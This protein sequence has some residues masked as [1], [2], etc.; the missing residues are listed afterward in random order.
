MAIREVDFR[1]RIARKIQHTFIRQVLWVL[2][3][4]G[5]DI[6]GFAI[7][8]WDTRGVTATTIECNSSPIGISMVPGF[9]K[10]ALNRRIAECNAVLEAEE[11]I[12]GPRPDG[13]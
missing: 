3:C 5:D 11:S 2:R 9:V 4:Q 1:K 10:D 8:A 12:L 6:A 13:A 7:V